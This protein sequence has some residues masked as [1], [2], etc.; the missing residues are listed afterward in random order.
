MRVC[1]GLHGRWSALSSAAKAAPLQAG[2]STRLTFGVEQARTLPPGSLHRPVQRLLPP[3]QR[4]QRRRQPRRRARCLA[5]GGR[6]A[7]LGWVRQRGGRPGRMSRLACV[8]RAACS[9]DEGGKHGGARA[10][11]GF[12]SLFGG[13]KVRGPFCQILTSARSCLNPRG[14]RQLHGGQPHHQACSPPSG[15]CRRRVHRCS[16]VNSYSAVTLILSRPSSSPALCCCCAGV[17]AAPPLELAAAAAACGASCAP[18]ALA[19]SARL[20]M[21]NRVFDTPA[22]RSAPAAP[23]VRGGR[24]ARAAAG[25]ATGRSA[26][27]LLVIPCRMLGG[28]YSGRNRRGMF[29]GG[30]SSGGSAVHMSCAKHDC[31]WCSSLLAQKCTSMKATEKIPQI[32]AGSSTMAYVMGMHA[33]ARQRW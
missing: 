17:G 8:S 14:H 32:L 12:P 13:Q 15:P 30:G 6:G 24:A 4:D 25:R 7:R 20:P 1:G 26:L 5:C 3:P 21:P 28:G 23:P 19:S 31:N 22:R 10:L 18:R 29:C 9:A 33:V 11:H 16:T 27:L 2:A